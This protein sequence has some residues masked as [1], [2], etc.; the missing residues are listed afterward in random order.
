[1][2]IITDNKWKP[3]LYGYELPK[4]IREQF[5]WLS[6]DDNDG[7][8]YYRKNWYHISEF[9]RNDTAEY[10]FGMQWHGSHGDSF[11]SGVII[12]ISQDGEC[13][14]VGRYYS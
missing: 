1:M 4:K 6:E 12:A 10:P 13:Y 2:T 11:F 3:F 8:F 7:F 9:M 5:D 14:K